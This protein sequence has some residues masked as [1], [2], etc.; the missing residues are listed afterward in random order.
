MQDTKCSVLYWPCSN[1]QV[2]SQCMQG[3]EEH[4]QICLSCGSPAGRVR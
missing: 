3:A 4:S 1:M 2:E